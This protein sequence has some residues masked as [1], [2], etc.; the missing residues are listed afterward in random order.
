MNEIQIFENDDFGKI[1]TLD[2]NGAVL[3]CGSDVAN[4]LG[5]ARPAKAVA[6]HCKGVLKRDTPLL[7][8]TKRCHLSQRETYTA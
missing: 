5:Y 2:E 6:D 1:R 7:V 4:A 8:A 3:F